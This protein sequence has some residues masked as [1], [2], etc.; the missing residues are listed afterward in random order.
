MN[1]ETWALG[2]WAQR[3]WQR[4]RDQF[5]AEFPRVAL[6]IGWCVRRPFWVVVFTIRGTWR[7]DLMFQASGLAFWALL[8]LIPFLA[9]LFAVLKAFGLLELAQPFLLE[10]LAAGHRGL[11]DMITQYVEAVQT[12]ALGGAGVIS[13]FV[14][15]FTL[16]QRLKKSLDRIWQTEHGLGYGRRL[17]EFLTILSVAPFLVVLPMGFST[18]L[19]STAIQSA[20]ADWE[21]LVLLKATTLANSGYLIYWLMLFYAYAYLP[22][23]KV[24]WRHALLGAVVAGS[25]LQVAQGFYITVM[26]QVTNYNVVY[27]AL[28]M[29]PFLM[30]WLYLGMA[31]FLIGAELSYCSQHHSVLLGTRRLAGRSEATRTHLALGL[32][33]ALL[34]EFRHGS[35]PVK[36][37]WLARRTGLPPSTVESLADELRTAGLITPVADAPGQFVPARPDETVTVREVLAKLGVIPIFGNEDPF[38]MTASAMTDSGQALTELFQDA[39][40]ALEK[41]LEEVTLRDLAQRMESGGPSGGQS[42]EPAG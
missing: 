34:Q 23:A 40:K 8:S 25:A 2:G 38:A 5:V 28:A 18:V 26:F 31:A 37:T 11:V 1:Q 27:G 14:V 19:K 9:L 10:T 3:H 30:I 13:L 39:N 16:L 21:L 4:W 7:N 33:T 41:P 35:A 12:A 32:M 36:L 22:D 6:W 17:I 42:G 24:R 15:G 20:I 29:L